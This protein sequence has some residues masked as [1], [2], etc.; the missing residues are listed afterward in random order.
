VATDLQLFAD[1]E[2]RVERLTTR[3]GIVLVFG[4]AENTF[5]VR[6]QGLEPA[7]VA[8]T[9]FILDLHTIFPG[10]HV[11]SPSSHSTTN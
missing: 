2:E 8:L 5:P 1:V 10:N 6:F 4:I 3:I 7:G 9:V 11:V